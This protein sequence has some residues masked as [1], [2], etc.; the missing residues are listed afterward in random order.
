MA[1]YIIKKER[2]IFTSNALFDI[3]SLDNT[4]LN[5]VRYNTVFI[6]K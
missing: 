6:R 1:N 4:F 2:S 3:L 5:N